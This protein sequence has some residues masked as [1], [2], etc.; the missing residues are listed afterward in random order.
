MVTGFDI[1][2][3][4]VARMIMMGLKFMDDVPFRT[5]YIHG[6]IRDSHGQKM[7]KSKGNVLDP[8]DLIN[9]IEL[10]PLIDKRTTGLMQPQM[11]PAIEKVT[12]EEFPNG[13]PAYGTD[14]LR[15]TFASLATTGR[16][17][18]F[19][20]GRIEGNRNFC[21]KL[22]NAARFVLMQT[23]GK[24]ASQSG[25]PDMIDTWIMSRLNRV[26]R[27]VDE[28]LTGY[29]LD[30]AAQALYEFIWNE[31][32]DWYLEFAK[33]TL[34]SGS[35]EQ[36]AN[37]RYTLLSVLETSLRT[38]HPMMPF[39]TEEIW[40]RLKEPLG[41]EGDTIMLQPFP[42]AGDEVAGAEDDVDWLKNVIQ[43]VRRVRSELDLPPGKLLDIWMQSGADLDRKR[44]EMFK[45]VLFQLGRI[46][47]SQW[48]ENNADSSQCAVALVGDLKILIPLKGLVDVEA[49]LARLQKQLAKE[50]NDLKKSEGK[51][52]NK[53]FV[54][55][56]PEAVVEQ[57]RQRLEAHKANTAN[58][59]LQIQQMESMRS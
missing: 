38:L 14:A 43:G 42:V 10:Q 20:L 21:N 6:L 33:A 26:L 11:A 53:R 35:P 39:I 4:W 8:L 44:H 7:S 15:F 52:G 12:R 56:A 30:L 19:E 45:S 55:N 13:I 50:Q 2:F 40:Q 27:E 36:Q 1:I 37:T 57:E 54:E 58:L 28:H 25:E 34:N 16:D 29:R 17:I 22:W 18:R 51:L 32:C 3:F 23:E 48:V 46:Q 41:L 47:S 31:Y 59:N 5:V 9:G 49:E 24:E